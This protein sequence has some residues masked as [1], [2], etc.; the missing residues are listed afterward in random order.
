MAN[1]ATKGEEA[2][3]ILP[4][5]AMSQY[6]NQLLTHSTLDLFQDTLKAVSATTIQS[7][8]ELSWAWRQRW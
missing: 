8:L 3:Q 4:I 2:S 7:T 6:F 1:G 5:F